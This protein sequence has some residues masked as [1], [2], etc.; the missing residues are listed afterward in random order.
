MYTPDLFV[1]SCNPAGARTQ[2]L[3][4]CLTRKQYDAVVTGY[5]NMGL[6]SDVFVFAKSIL[7][8]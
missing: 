3:A 4:W 5:I 8:A 7:D 1:T 6:F 2:G